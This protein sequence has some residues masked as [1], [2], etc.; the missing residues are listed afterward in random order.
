VRALPEKVLK[1]VWAD[2]I[3]FIFSNLVS[4]AL[5]AT[6]VSATGLRTA[7]GFLALQPNTNDTLQTA[8]K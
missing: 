6:V 8:R 4:T 3:A 2:F 7:N 1:A 5:T